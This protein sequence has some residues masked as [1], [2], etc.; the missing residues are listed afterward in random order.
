MVKLF[1][2]SIPM[3]FS[4]FV[5]AVA[6]VIGLAASTTTAPIVPQQCVS[7]VRP[8]AVG[9]IGNDV[10]ALQTFLGV[11][12]T[13]Y[14]GPMTQTA[15]TKWQ[16]SNHV[17]VSP[18][19]SGAG[20]A[21]PKTRAALR[22]QSDVSNSSVPVTIIPAAKT[23]L[24]MIAPSNIPLVTASTTQVIEPSP[25]T[26]GGSTVGTQVSQTITGAKCKPFTTPAP[27]AS[28]CTTGLWTIID[29]EADCPVE[30]NCSDP[31]ATQ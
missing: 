3:H 22:C 4:S 28:Q 21:G 7:I 17:T 31:N 10:S 15:L 26:G 24:P 8:L 27:P 6:T 25:G 2:T 13:G 23:V 1:T 14:F 16:I 11:K 20:I 5:A 19:S 9:S 29:D 30:W 18:R 12:S